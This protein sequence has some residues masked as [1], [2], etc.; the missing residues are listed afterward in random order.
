MSSKVLRYAIY[1]PLIGHAR[2]DEPED[3]AYGVVRKVKSV[4]RVVNQM[5]FERRT[6]SHNCALARQTEQV[7][8]IEIGPSREQLTAS[9]RVAQNAGAHIRRLKT[10]C[11]ECVANNEAHEHVVDRTVAARRRKQRRMMVTVPSRST[12]PSFE[13][14][15]RERGQRYVAFI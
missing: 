6:Q 1:S 12:E 8:Y 10:D 13:R 5:A 9:V 7:R 3:P 11:L 2:S 14:W 4:G 15:R